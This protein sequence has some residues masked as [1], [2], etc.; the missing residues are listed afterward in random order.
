[1]D[2]SSSESV[3]YFLNRKFTYKEKTFLNRKTQRVF[4]VKCCS[5]QTINETSASPKVLNDIKMLKYKELE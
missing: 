1:M 2:F 4:L 3:I 5:I